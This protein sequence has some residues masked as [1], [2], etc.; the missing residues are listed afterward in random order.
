MSNIT[1]VT[2]QNVDKPPGFRFLRELRL[3]V[4]SHEIFV[5]T[6]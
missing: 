3:S 5:Y 1:Q 2:L 6:I 4:L